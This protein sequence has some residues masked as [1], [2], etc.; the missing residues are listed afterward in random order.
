MLKT[1]LE[2]VLKTSCNMKNCYV[3][4]SFITFYRRLGKQEMFVGSAL[5]FSRC[6]IIFHIHT[7][8]IFTQNI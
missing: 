1:R 8:H 3:E 6:D 4:D 5:I 2:D 7:Q